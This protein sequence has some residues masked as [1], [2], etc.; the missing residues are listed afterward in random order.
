MLNAEDIQK[1]CKVNLPTKIKIWKP[2]M[3][4]Y[5]VIWAFNVWSSLLWISSTPRSFYHFF[6]SH[7]CSY[8]CYHNYHDISI[9]FMITVINMIAIYYHYYWNTKLQ[10]LQWEPHK[11]LFNISLKNKHARIVQ[12]T[13]NH[14]HN[15][16]RFFDGLLSFLFTTNFLWLIVTNMVYTSYLASWKRL[17]A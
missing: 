13:H 8:H 5:W 17:K 12:N 15:I 7:C 11:N 16:F 14:G 6:I 10:W 2:S 4:K 3:Y 1:T 9:I